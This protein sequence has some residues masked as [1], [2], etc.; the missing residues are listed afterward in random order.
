MFIHLDHFTEVEREMKRYCRQE[1]YLS[2]ISLSDRQSY[3]NGAFSFTHQT[4]ILQSAEVCRRLEML[5]PTFMADLQKHGVRITEN[6]LRQILFLCVSCTLLWRS[7]F[8]KWRHYHHE[9][10]ICTEQSDIF[11]KDTLLLHKRRCST[12][13]TCHVKMI[14]RPQ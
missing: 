7:S 9:A 4:P 3:P 2:L 1:D 11:S 12:Y 5:H 10:E 14:L 6:C 13:V 8:C